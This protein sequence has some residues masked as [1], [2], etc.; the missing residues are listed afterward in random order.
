[1]GISD[2]TFLFAKTT[3]DRSLIS[4]RQLLA[5]LFHQA[6]QNTVHSLEVWIIERGKT[7]FI[8]S[9]VCIS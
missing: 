2:L 5:H 8:R 3:L 7:C 9:E 4:F 1:M 6:F